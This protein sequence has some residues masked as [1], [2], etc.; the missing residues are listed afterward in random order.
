MNSAL[1]F[2]SSLV[3]E[4]LQNYKND[5]RVQSST[6]ACLQ[7]AA[8]AYLVILFEDAAL[9]CKHRQGG[10]VF[11]KD[12]KLVQTLRGSTANNPNVEHNSS[13]QI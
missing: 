8:E 13:K 6:L 10:T 7:E 5:F 4:I 3:Q 1:H 9:C 11:N 12:M 2:N